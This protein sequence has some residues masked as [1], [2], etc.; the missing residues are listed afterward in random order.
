M[1]LMSGVELPSRAIREQIASAIDI[2][3]QQSRLKCGARKITRICEITGMEGDIITLQD[4]FIF[5]QHGFDENGKTIGEFKSSGYTPRFFESLREM[6]I[7][8]DM[9]IFQ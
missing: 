5:E 8:L 4:I 7:S 2:I 6:G 3:V 9:S 1:V